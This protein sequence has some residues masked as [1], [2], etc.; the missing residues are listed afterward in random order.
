[1]VI[2]YQAP[3]VYWAQLCAAPKTKPWHAKVTIVNRS[4]GGGGGGA[5]LSN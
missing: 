2:N 3:A 4:G 1:M 5:Q